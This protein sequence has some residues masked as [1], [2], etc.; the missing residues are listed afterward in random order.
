MRWEML[1]NFEWTNATLFY[2]LYQRPASFWEGSDLSRRWRAGGRGTRSP[3]A[4]WWARGFC[5]PEILTEPAVVPPPKN[6]PS[7]NLPDRRTLR[8]AAAL[9]DEAGWGAG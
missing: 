8:R 1:F 2:D 9:L 7:Q 4:A 6:D 5:S 3:G